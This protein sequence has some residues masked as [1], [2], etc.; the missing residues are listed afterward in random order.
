MV[1][2]TPFQRFDLPKKLAGERRF[3]PETLVTGFAPQAQMHVSHPRLKGTPEDG[4]LLSIQFEQHAD[5]GSWLYGS[6]LRCCRRS[7][8]RWD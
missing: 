4:Q 7:D 5:L 3:A 1:T 6:S 2:H 8:R